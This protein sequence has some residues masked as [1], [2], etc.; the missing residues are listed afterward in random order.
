MGDCEVC[1]AR[2]AVGEFDLDG[3]EALLCRVCS[4]TRNEDGSVVLTDARGNRHA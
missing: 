3:I 4:S 2:P 1:N